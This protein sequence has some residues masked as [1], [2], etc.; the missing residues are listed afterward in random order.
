MRDLDRYQADYEAL[1]FEAIQAAYRRRHVLDT[2]ARF[3]GADVLEVGCGTEALFLHYTAFRSMHVVEP[4]ERFFAR[5]SVAAR[6]R[7]NV[8]V[9]LGSLQQ[10]GTQLAQ[11]KFDSIVVSSLLHEIQDPE[12]LLASALSLCTEDTTLHVYVPNARS[13]HRLLALE[14]GLIRDVHEVSATQARM[15]QSATYDR[16]TLAALL[17]RAGFDVVE[18]GSFFIKPFTHAQMAGLR[19]KGLLTDAMLDGLYG[20]SRHLPDAG[21]ELYA[22]ARR[23]R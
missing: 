2:L 22:I 20:L 21:S 9:L 5:A 11:N 3:G 1:P 6:D 16:D 18:S 12:T 15:Q 10:V 17:R 7:S 8:T 4:A 23:K 19:E 13:F 14:M